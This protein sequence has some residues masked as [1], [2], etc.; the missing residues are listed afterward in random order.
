MSIVVAD[1]GLQ[2][3]RTAMSWTRTGL[4]MLVC[5]ATLLRWADAYPELIVFAVCALT[6]GAV[7]IGL[8]NRRLYRRDAFALADERSAPN[9]APIAILTA[10]MLGIAVVGLYLVLA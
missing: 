6:L 9:T 10:M 3:E 7:A 4:A 2:P 5:A 8:L 1:P